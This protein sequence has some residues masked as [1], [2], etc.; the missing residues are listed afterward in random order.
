MKSGLVC[1]WA[2]IKQSSEVY[3]DDDCNGGKDDYSD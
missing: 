2:E 3:M 1:V